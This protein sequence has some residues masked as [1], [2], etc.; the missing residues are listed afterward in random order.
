MADQDID[1][2]AVRALITAINAGDRA[3]VLCRADP[4]RN[5]VQRRHRP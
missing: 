1:D 3:G 4:G 5:H 2:P